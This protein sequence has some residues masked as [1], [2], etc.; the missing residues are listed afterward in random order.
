MNAIDYDKEGIVF[1]IQRY[2]IHDGPGLRTIV[3]LKGCPLRCRW[4]S[5]P[6]SQN[7]EPELFFPRVRLHQVRP[8]HTGLPDQGARSGQCGL[9]RSQQMHQVRQLHQGLSNRGAE[10]RRQEHERGRGDA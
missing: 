3:F 9:R 6:E 5:N 10:A 4:C 8:V 1:D 7:P 2:S